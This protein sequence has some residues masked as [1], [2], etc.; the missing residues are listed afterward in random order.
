MKKWIIRVA[1]IW[2]V[3][4][5]A[6]CGRATTDGSVSGELI[7]SGESQDAEVEGD[8]SE[9]QQIS[10]DIES[11]EELFSGFELLMTAVVDEA[12]E[13]K[14]FE[15]SWQIDGEMVTVSTRNMFA[16]TQTV[17]QEREF[18][19][20]V[21]A[22]SEAYYGNTTKQVTVMPSPMKD[23]LSS[24]FNFRTEPVIEREDYTFIDPGQVVYQDDKFHMFYNAIQG[25]SPVFCGYATSEDGVSWTKHSKDAPIMTQLDVRE[26]TGN[27]TSRIHLTSVIYEDDRWVAYLT[28]VD[29]PF[30]HGRILKATAADPL[31]EW[32][33]RAIPV[34]AVD[35]G[36]W[37]GS[38]L[39]IPHVFKLSN[40]D[41]VMYYHAISNQISRAV[42]SDGVEWV[43][44]NDT[45]TDT[46]V[47]NDSDPLLY[48]DTPSVARTSWG[49]IL[50]IY[51][52][53]YIS[54]DGIK[55]HRYSKPLYSPEERQ[56]RGISDQWIT[57]LIVHEGTVY[58]YI[59]GGA[60]GTSNIYLITWD[61]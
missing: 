8:R 11:G 47:I 12:F 30:F 38:S 2:L 24:N 9:K 59:E 48:G 55:W 46:V 40:N 16:F 23:P 20:S 39:G 41:Y 61:L 28:E 17:E 22:E 45:A 7:E 56:E 53:M 21:T 36:S 4:L 57:A 42:S 10:L 14:S 49:W 32:D 3:S 19:V 60:R 54:T 52:E 26:A 50:A 15:Y 58:Y 31:G 43:K 44:Y 18:T 37:E 6:G 51:E 35:E 27:S 5:L 13:D 29:N 1:A 33:I 34:L 25:N